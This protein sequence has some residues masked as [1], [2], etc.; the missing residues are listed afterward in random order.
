MTL[1]DQ[2]K[3]NGGKSMYERLLDKSIRP[4]IS[5]MIEW[6]VTYR[7]NKKLFCDVFPE[8][9]AL[10]VMLRLSDDS[11]QKA[12]P[13]LTQYTQEQIDAKYPCGSGGWIHYRIT[14]KE[15]LDDIIKLLALKS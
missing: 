8:C 7:R 13:S 3:V 10:N 9:G 4:N 14:K 11:F 2:L 1:L 12:Y 15:H 6:C 5:N